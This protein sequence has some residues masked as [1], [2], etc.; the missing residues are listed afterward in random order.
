M[1]HSTTRILFDVNDNQNAYH[2]NNNTNEVQN[3]NKYADINYIKSDTKDQYNEKAA[4]NNKTDHVRNDV[5]YDKGDNDKNYV[6]TKQNTMH[7]LD[8]ADIDDKS[9]S[10]T[11]DQNMLW[12]VKK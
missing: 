1:K 2:I 10:F 9:K 5:E 11:R 3:Y 8:N 12:H 6:N 7:I 4:N